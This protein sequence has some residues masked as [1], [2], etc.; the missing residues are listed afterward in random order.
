MQIEIEKQVE[1]KSIWS[2]EDKIYAA[3]IISDWEKC[4]TPGF[5]IFINNIESKMKWIKSVKERLKDE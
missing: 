5:P 2:E 4:T 1:H 3:Q